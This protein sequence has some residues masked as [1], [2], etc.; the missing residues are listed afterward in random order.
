MSING[1]SVWYGL[2]MSLLHIPTKSSFDNRFYVK[3]TPETD[4]S[5]I[6][7]LKIEVE[8]DNGGAELILKKHKNP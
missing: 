8:C 2:W 3:R 7:E 4:L 6:D 5:K 1:I